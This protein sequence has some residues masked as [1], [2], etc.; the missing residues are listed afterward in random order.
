MGTT[1]PTTT[2]STS[3][4]RQRQDMQTKLDTLLQAYTYALD[5]R[6][7]RSKPSTAWAQTAAESANSDGSWI[8][9]ALQPQFTQYIEADERRKKE[10]EALDAFLASVPHQMKAL[11]QGFSQ[12]A[13]DAVAAE[14][15]RLQLRVDHGIQLQKEAEARLE[16]NDEL[17][18]LVAAA[19]LPDIPER[20]DVATRQARALEAL[21]KQLVA[22]Q[23]WRLEPGQELAR[24]LYDLRDEGRRLNTFVASIHEMIQEAERREKASAAAVAASAP[25]AGAPPAPAPTTSPA[26]TTTASATPAGTSGGGSTAAELAAEPYDKKKKS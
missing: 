23:S 19:K 26:A 10:V 18:D 4:V 16:Q 3:L 22:L 2:G 24:F 1:L 20:I 14:K 12:V 13:L 21:Q 15:S 8:T 6:E 7:K 11:T 5:E 17:R 9:S 25:P